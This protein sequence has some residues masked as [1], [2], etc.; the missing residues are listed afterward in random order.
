MAAIEIDSY[1]TEEE[2]EGMLRRHPFSKYLPWEVYDPERK[3]YFN[4]DETWGILLECI[5]LIFASEKTYMTL[6]GLFRLPLPNGS[7]LQ[8]ILYADPY[9][10]PYLEAYERLK[11][12][13][14]PIVE[15]TTQAY[16]EFLRKGAKEGLGVTQGIPV[17]N[18]RLF[19]ALKIPL[20]NE[21]PLTESY[22]KE[23][24]ESF[25]ECLK[26]AGLAPSYMEPEDLLE[27]MRR[28]LNTQP[29]FNYRGYDPNKLIREQVILS[30]TEIK[31]SFQDI[32]FGD[33]IFKCITP[34][35]FPKEISPLIMNFIFGGVWGVA[36]DADQIKSP[37]MFS[38][39]YLYEDLR[40]QI[41]RKCSLILKQQA[42]G[43]FAPSLMRKK[44]EFLWATD[45]LERGTKFLRVIPVLWVMS[46]DE[47]RLYESV[48][49]AKRMWESEGFVVQEDRGILPILFIASLP[50]GF[51]NKGK[52][53]EFLDRDFIAPDHTLALTIPCQGDYMGAGKPVLLFVSRKGQIAGVDI[54]DKRA[55]N[56]NLYVA[57]SSGSGKSFFV[58]YLAYNYYSTG[59]YIR[60]IDI[61]GSYKKMTK[62]F[63]ANYMDFSDKSDIVINPFTGIIE[64][65]HDL[66]VIASIVAQMIFSYEDRLPDQMEMSLIKDA[67]RWAYDSKGNDAGIDDVYTY[68][69]TYPE[70]SVSLVEGAAQEEIT[71]LSHKL[72]FNLRD[73]KSD[74]I[75][76]RWFNGKAT[77][78]IA[79]DDFVVLE[80]EHLK[81]KK[82]LFKVVTLQV[83]NAVTGDLY[84][85]DRQTPRLIIFDEAWQ[86]LKEGAMLKS[87]IEEGYRRARKYNGSFTV[88][89]Q[90]ALDI[91]QFGDVG[92]VIRASSQWKFYLESPDFDRALSEK[93]LDYNEFEMKLLKTVKSNKPKYSE[94]WVEGPHGSGVARLIV[95]P[96]SYF[97][98]TSDP[99]EIA[100][101][102]QLIDSGY[103]IEEAV[104]E[105]V[106]RYRS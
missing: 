74:G 98:Y 8:F 19:A 5:P 75:Y 14:L 103:T 22:I 63:N 12:R 1:V 88:I 28:L 39:N 17:R 102:E 33:R 86:F 77:F 61:G 100:E 96:V 29:M 9:I 24:R 73:W 31:K 38:I 97:I 10:E 64:P 15:R 82:E 47:N 35:G 89:T 11:R 79:K 81:P 45:E 13:K 49:R 16:K 67:V 42:A 70:H 93:L 105:M 2:L 37:F 80:L 90:S 43:S 60:I 21:Q 83:I 59:A 62:L 53:V 85:S 18:F 99:K 55:N 95:D 87:V 72:A 40:F 56:Y 69:S 104:D 91:K 20:N 48:T 44:E 84:L 94:I 57:A 32:R 65:E 23:I 6:N 46:E 54:F 25:Y 34:K 3:I 27:T 4:Q 78:N 26:G 7:V 101:I 66:P 51:Y 41:H 92:D 30:E 68:L 76:G 50:F 58:N 52:N 71:V 106:R 36:S